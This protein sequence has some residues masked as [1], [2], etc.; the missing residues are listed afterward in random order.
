ML[1]QR[2]SQGRPLLPVEFLSR[3][4]TLDHRDR[5]VAYLPAQPQRPLDRDPEEP[6]RLIG[7]DLHPLPFLELTVEAGDLFD[8][9]RGDFLPLLAEGPAYLREVLASV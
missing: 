2:H 5:L 3:L 1:L 8:L 6:E 9:R 4:G 7:E